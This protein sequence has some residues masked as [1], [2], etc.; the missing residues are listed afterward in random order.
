[1]SMCLS[2]S[3]LW[4]WHGLISG[5]GVLDLKSGGLWFKFP[6]LLLAEFVCATSP[7]FNSSAI[8]CK[9]L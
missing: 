9:D 2:M 5:L 6:S 8:L 4:M 7:E 1:M 3:E